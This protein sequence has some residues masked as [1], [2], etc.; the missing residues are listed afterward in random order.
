MEHVLVVI[1][2]S[3]DNSVRLVIDCMHL[4]YT[5][6]LLMVTVDVVC[7]PVVDGDC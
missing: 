7:V 4:S 2:T 3:F 5:G 6:A 1:Q